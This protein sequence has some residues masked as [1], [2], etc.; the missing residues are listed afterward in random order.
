[1]N[2]TSFTVSYH[3]EDAHL[4]LMEK[5]K[6]SIQVKVKRIQHHQT[7]FT[8]NAEGTCL[9]RKH[10]VVQDLQKVNPKHLRKL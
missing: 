6:L 9:G 5:S 8:T 3:Q 1:M 4:D 10:K 7:S 2:L